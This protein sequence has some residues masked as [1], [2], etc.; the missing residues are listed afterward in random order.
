MGLK[1]TSNGVDC[2]EQGAKDF[3]LRIA[4]R[5]SGG[6]ISPLQRACQ[7][8]PGLCKGGRGR[9]RDTSWANLSDHF[10]HSPY[11]GSAAGILDLFP[12]CFT[13]PL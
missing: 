3:E 8:S 2:P 10:L 13:D 4:R 11:Y 7:S 12:R 6:L 9:A 5:Q 1:Q